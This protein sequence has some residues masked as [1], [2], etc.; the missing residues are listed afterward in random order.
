MV[1]QTI[2]EFQDEL[3]ALRAE[4]AANPDSIDAKLVAAWLDKL[5]IALQGL[6]TNLGLM[7]AG[8]ELLAQ[9]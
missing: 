6:T 8:V 5:I 9:E 7:S 1:I 2:E 4:I 3:K